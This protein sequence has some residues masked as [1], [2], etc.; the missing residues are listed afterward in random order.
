MNM[1]LEG[2]NLDA[3]KYL[4]EEYTNK[5]KMI[6]IDPPYNTRSKFV[7]NDSN[8]Q[9]LEFM[10]QRLILAK[11]LLN[12]EGVI[13][14]SID[15]NELYRL[16]ILMDD[17]FGSNNF[18]CNFIRQDSAGSGMDNKFLN[19][20]HDYI[21]TYAKD[22]TKLKLNRE[23]ANIEKNYKLIDQH[24]ETR[25]KY[26]LIN[27]KNKKNNINMA[28]PIIH[29]DK[30][31]KPDNDG[32]YCWRWSED[33]IK[34]GIENDYIVFKNNSIFFKNYQFVDNKNQPYKRTLPFKTII[35]FLNTKGSCDMKKLDMKHLFDYPKPVEL[36]KYLLQIGTNKDDI[37]LDFFAGSGTTAHA[38]LEL[39]KEDGGNRK[40]ICVQLPEPTKPDSL[41]YKNGY[42]TI[43]E[44]TKE[45][46]RR[47]ISLL[48]NN[49]EFIIKK[50]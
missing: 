35:K 2:D 42:H 38:V 18:I 7:Y 20:E 30:I 27:M 43:A 4:Q 37:I 28:K 50:M 11:N 17:I 40:F 46:I 24:V 48:D 6:Y 34:W 36:I 33:R 49:D 26:Y 21:L 29:G 16:K 41:P 3:L 47:V 44:I 32:F 15:D 8:N 45:R 1:F 9:W 19:V 31:Y 39:N 14:I 23:P 25:G 5:I 22:K 10:K 13:F 12:N